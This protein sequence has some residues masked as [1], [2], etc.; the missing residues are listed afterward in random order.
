MKQDQLMPREGYVVDF[1]SGVQVKATPEEVEATQLFSKILV[2]DYGY[3]KEHIQTRPQ[4]HVK[5]RPSD[6]K[7]EYPVDIAVFNDSEKSDDS[8]F[9]IVECKKKNRKDGRSQLENYLTLSN[10]NLGVWY[11]GSE[12]FFLL[13]QVTEDGH[14]V[15]KDIPA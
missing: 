14:V 8:V 4:Y 11:N 7:K 1:I 3:P 12:R 15:F 10:A 6:T 13:K 2:E 5:V 9:M